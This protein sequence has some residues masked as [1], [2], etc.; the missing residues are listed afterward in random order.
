MEFS[1]YNSQFTA[2][3]ETTNN[4]LQEKFY[5]LTA[6][7]AQTL[8]Q[9]SLTA[10]EW[11]LWSYLA[12]LDPW[13]VLRS[14]SLRDRYEPLPDILTIMQA[15]EIKKSTFYK[16]IAKFQEFKIFDF[17]SLGL[18]FRNLFGV[19]KLRN[20]FRENGKVSENSES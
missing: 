13:G 6:D 1:T 5:P 19:S 4:K 11:R 3:S 14:R 2:T 12:E 10:S 15:V 16:A 9:A 7:V 18:S 17:Q 20:N 8:R